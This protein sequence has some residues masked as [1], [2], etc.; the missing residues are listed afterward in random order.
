[1]NAIQAVLN[2][3]WTDTGGTLAWLLLVVGLLVRV[4]AR[5]PR[6]A[7]GQARLWDDRANGGADE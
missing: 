4:R 7:D 3:G 1:M 2:S 5:S 6:T